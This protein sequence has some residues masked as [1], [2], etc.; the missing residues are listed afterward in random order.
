MK[1]NKIVFTV[2]K[3]SDG[4]FSAIGHAGKRNQHLIAA[5]GDTWE[6]L[7]EMALDAV[8]LYL[9]RMDIAPVTVD[10][11]DYSFDLPSFFDAYPHIDT[12]ALSNHARR[13][14]AFPSQHAQGIKKTPDRQLHR[15]L[16]AVKPLGNGL[17]G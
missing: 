8:N 17:F 9:K 10:N 1:R 6:E 11:V 16:E 15:I 4:G 5:Q 7:K 3:E 14:N 2:I 13:K 12:T